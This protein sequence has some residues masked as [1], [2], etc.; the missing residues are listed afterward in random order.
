MERIMNGE[1]IEKVR[2]YVDQVLLQMDDP[3]ERRCA[4]I[5]LYGVAQACAMIAQKRKANVELAIIAGMLHDIFS[6]K[7]MDHRNHAEKGA[8]MA[9]E[10][11]NELESFHDSEVQ[12]ICDAIWHH[13]NKTGI[14]TSFAEILKDAD[15]LQHYLYDPFFDVADPAKGRLGNLQKEFGL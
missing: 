3:V 5:H 8:A 13:S 2:A 15:V 6:Y 1:R 9:K 11:L 4:Y 7:T 14:H 12:I 10:I